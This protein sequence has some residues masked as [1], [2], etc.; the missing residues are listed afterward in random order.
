MSSLIW[1]PDG[2]NEPRQEGFNIQIPNEMPLLPTRDVVVFPLMLMP[3]MVGR[4]ISINA[5]NEAL[6]RDRLIFVV[7]QKDPQVEL[8]GAKD[9]YTIGTV[10]M[11]MRMVKTPDDKIKILVQGLTRAKTDEFLQFNPYIKVKLTPLY[12]RQITELTM[13]TEAHMRLVKENL[14][15]AASLGKPIPP[16][17]L[18][19][20]ATIDDPGKLADLWRHS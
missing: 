13:E 10:C 17:A 14:E 6:S 16:E 7:A 12:D 4:D 11:I 2:G 3:L 8:P 1:T 5:V 19:L 9:L 20:L 18:T 15:K